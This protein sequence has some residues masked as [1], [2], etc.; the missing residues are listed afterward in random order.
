MDL[1]KKLFVI[2]IVRLWNRMPREVVDTLSLEILK[3]RLEGALSNLICCRCPCS[4]Q[5]GWTR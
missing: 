2:R 4:L 3:V 5:G 1:K